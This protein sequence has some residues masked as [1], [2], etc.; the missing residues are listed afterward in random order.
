M[1]IPLLNDSFRQFCTAWEMGLIKS[2]FAKCDKI[3]WW[4]KTHLPSLIISP[5]HVTWIW[6]MFLIKW[7]PP[8]RAHLI[9]LIAGVDWYI[10]FPDIVHRCIGI[11]LYVIHFVQCQKIWFKKTHCKN[12]K[13]LHF[14]SSEGYVFHPLLSFNSVNVDC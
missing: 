4:Y 7:S 10:S 3:K 2:R 8:H 14:I 12:R 6:W 1:Q 5:I 11:S 13:S 9:T